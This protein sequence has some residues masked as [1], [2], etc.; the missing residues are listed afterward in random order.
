MLVLEYLGR[1]GRGGEEVV[2]DVVRQPP[3]VLLGH[4]EVVAPEARLDVPDRDPELGRGHRAG[5][6]RVRVALDEDAVRLARTRT[7]PRT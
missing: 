6:D 1:L 3:V 5:E 4:P 7:R 2:R